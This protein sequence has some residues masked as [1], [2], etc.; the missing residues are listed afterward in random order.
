METQISISK[1]LV[2]HYLSCQAICNDTQK[3][4]YHESYNYQSFNLPGE[5]PEW[6]ALI[7]VVKRMNSGIFECIDK[8]QNLE[9]VCMTRQN[10]LLHE[11]RQYKA[12]H[13]PGSSTEW[14]GISMLD[15]K[16]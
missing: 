9:K 4:I 15:K 11:I 3:I 14:K 12:L 2:N 8:H 13:I 1:Y 7:A 16:N 6:A 5:S 10:N